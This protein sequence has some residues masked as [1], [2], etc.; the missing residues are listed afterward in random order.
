MSQSILPK[1][2]NLLS[3][4]Y[5]CKIQCPANGSLSLNGYTGR[6]QNKMVGLYNER[7][8]IAG[9]QLIAIETDTQTNVCM[10]VISKCFQVRIGSLNTTFRISIL[11]VIHYSKFIYKPTTILWL[12]YILH[13]DWFLVFGY[14]LNI[15][16][17]LLFSITTAKILPPPPP[18]D[19]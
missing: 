18:L 15:I 9:K 1:W 12:Q 17:V 13:Q 16:A 8:L 5:Q 2:N 7:Q 4:L 3:F 6:K 11:F 19:K 10:S 14:D